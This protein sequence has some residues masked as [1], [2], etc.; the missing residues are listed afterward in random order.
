MPIARAPSGV[1]VTYIPGRSGTVT[2]DPPVRSVSLIFGTIERLRAAAKDK[3][4]GSI[5]LD[6]SFSRIR[7]SPARE[8]HF[9]LNGLDYLSLPR[10]SPGKK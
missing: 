3:G 1:A 9:N 4:D 5:F 8:I 10:F 6:K 7:I 2:F